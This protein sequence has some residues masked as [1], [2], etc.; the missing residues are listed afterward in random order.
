MGARGPKIWEGRKHPKFG[1]ISDNFIF[2]FDFPKYFSGGPKCWVLGFKVTPISDHLAKFH[3]QRPREL[4]NSALK[5]NKERKKDISSETERHSYRCIACR[6]GLI[7]GYTI[8][9]CLFRCGGNKEFIHH[10]R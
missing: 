10:K 8:R 9:R 1:A 5:K 2:Q 3:G 7:C 6:G 4:G